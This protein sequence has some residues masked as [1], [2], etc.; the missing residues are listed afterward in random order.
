MFNW[1][2][3]FLVIAVVAAI[4]GFGNLVGAATTV[5]RILFFVFLAVFVIALF[6]GAVRQPPPPPG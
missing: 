6:L 4:L 3:V 1:A 5:A 2:V